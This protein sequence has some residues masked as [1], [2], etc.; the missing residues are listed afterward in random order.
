VFDPQDEVDL[1]EL[2]VNATFDNYAHQ[3]TGRRDR[4]R[5]HFRPRAPPGT[6][7]HTHACS[8]SRRRVTSRRFR[9][10]VANKAIGANNDMPFTRLG[11]RFG[12]A[13]VAA[14]REGLG[15]RSSQ[16]L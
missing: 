2:R 11:Q 9:A 6:A 12:M 1:P 7:G 16:G 10:V 14:K 3:G 8:V 5:L 4:P 13:T 15:Q